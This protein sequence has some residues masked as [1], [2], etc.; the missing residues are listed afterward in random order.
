MYI[1]HPS[2][3]KKLTTMDPKSP[4]PSH[5]RRSAGNVHVWS[6]L[7]KVTKERPK[8]QK[9]VN[10]VT[11]S[12]ADSV[13]TSTG[14]GFPYA[15]HGLPMAFPCFPPG[16]S[17]ETPAGLQGKTDGCQGTVKVSWVVWMRWASRGKLR[18]RTR[19]SFLGCI[20]LVM[21]LKDIE[22][23]WNDLSMFEPDHVIITLSLC[24]HK[25]SSYTLRD[26]TSNACGAASARDLQAHFHDPRQECWNNSPWYD[27]WEQDYEEKIEFQVLHKLTIVHFNSLAASA[28]LFIRFLW[29]ALQPLGKVWLTSTS[30]SASTT[31]K[32]DWHT[33][34]T[35]ARRCQL[36]AVAVKSFSSSRASNS[37]STTCSRGPSIHR[38]PADQ[39]FHELL[40]FL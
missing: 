6:S 34:Y 37:L 29:T 15:F 13:T 3:A 4:Q 27:R 5:V 18:R 14:I 24:T 17:V 25:A 9:T 23:N 22:R 28:I 20:E 39:D 30:L 32:E 40:P 35:N 26:F 21:K 1:C 31:I 36:W 11:T 12:S 2:D 19:K 10:E 38:S 7:L 33:Q 8:Y 16:R